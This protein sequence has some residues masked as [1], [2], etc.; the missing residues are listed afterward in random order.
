MNT[1]KA[2]ISSNNNIL[3]IAAGVKYCF[4]ESRMEIIAGAK[5]DDRYA[6]YQIDCEL[7]DAA[8]Q[9]TDT[10]PALRRAIESAKSQANRHHEVAAGLTAFKAQEKTELAE[11]K[12]RQHDGWL[13]QLA[14]FGDR[15][16][17]TANWFRDQ[18]KR[19]GERDPIAE[20]RTHFTAAQWKTRVLRDQHTPDTDPDYGHALAFRIQK[21]RA[22]KR[23]LGYGLHGT[24]T[25][26]M[27][28]HKERAEAIR[29]DRRTAAINRWPK[30]CGRF[31]T[32]ARELERLPDADLRRAEREPAFAAELDRRHKLAERRAKAATK[33]TAFITPIVLHIGDRAALAAGI[34]GRLLYGGSR[35]SESRKGRNGWYTVCH[36]A[37]GVR[38]TSKDEIILEGTHNRKPITIGKLPPLA[39]LKSITLS[40]P[41]PVG[42]FCTPLAEMPGV[43]ACFGPEGKKWVVV[44]YSVAGHQVPECV[45][46]GTITP[47]RK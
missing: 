15:A 28:K 8:K 44:G 45:A 30:L 39:L 5:F 43:S 21:L 19:R 36:A 17:K 6:P 16:R 40:E 34:R 24:F 1:I 29:E 31:A 23:R 22:E 13:A 11:A 25:S 37:P 12:A 42:L 32:K 33:R 3:V 46:T 10:W 4:I 41:H 2:G 26:R 18:S 9:E 38:L 7:F 47:T 27:P 14:A 35:A 20:A